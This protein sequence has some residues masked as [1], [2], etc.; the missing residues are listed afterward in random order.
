MTRE[1]IESQENEISKTS[2]SDPKLSR[3]YVKQKTKRTE[4][5]PSLP[6][7]EGEL[8]VSDQEK[9]EVL[10]QFFS[11]VFT[12]EDPEIGRSRG[13]LTGKERYVY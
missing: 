1:K 10:S 4:S 3:N 7:E 11:S 13:K 5:I 2:K 8:T 6:K 12:H 9:A